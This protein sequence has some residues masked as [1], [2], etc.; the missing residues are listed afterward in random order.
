MTLPQQQEPQPHAA[1]P[2]APSPGPLLNRSSLTRIA[3]FALYM[4][5]IAITDGLQRAGWTTAELYWLYPVKVGVVLLALLACWRSYTELAWRGMQKGML[6]ASVAVGLAVFVLWV[7]LDASWMQIGSPDGYQPRN[8][9]GQLDW[10][11]IA[12][13]LAGAAV[14]V[15]LMEELFWRSFLMRWIDAPDFLHVQPARV[16]VKALLF[17]VVLFG[18]EHSLWL[19]G[20]AAGAAYGLLYMRTGTL[21]APILAHAV[22]NG[23]LGVWVVITGNWTYW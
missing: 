23:S 20:M 16:T 13:R 22:T 7:N 11:L 5:F 8:A 3:P 6:L 17:T 2:A 10:P 14:V 1:A 19:A 9:A 12:V 21:W 4:A 15:P 18:F